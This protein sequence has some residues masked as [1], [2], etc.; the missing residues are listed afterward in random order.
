MI[1]VVDRNNLQF[2]SHV[3]FTGATTYTWSTMNLVHSLVAQ[4]G[5]TTVSTHSP[6]QDMTQSFSGHG[7]YHNSA[8]PPL[9]SCN[10]D[11]CQPHL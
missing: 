4:D 10:G 6:F 2:L 5:L 11:T 7:M 1:F 8:T 9:P 3:G